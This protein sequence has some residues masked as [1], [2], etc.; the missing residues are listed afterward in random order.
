MYVTRFI[1]IIILF[2][3]ITSIFLVYI[4]FFDSDFKSYNHNHDQDHF[5]NNNIDSNINSNSKLPDKCDSATT[6]GQIC[7]NYPACCTIIGNEYVCKHPLITTCKNEYE[8]CMNDTNILKIYPIN[9]RTEKCIS[10]LGNCCKPFDSINT[11]DTTKFE[12]IKNLN[13]IKMPIQHELG[14]LTDITNMS[15]SNTNINMNTK[16]GILCQT[17]ENCKAYKVGFGGCT[18]Y[19]KYDPQILLSKFGNNE[20]SYSNANS[21]LLY[22]KI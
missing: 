3:F 6:P 17:D 7:T 21:N 18:F 2:I 8:K 5:T 11:I 15:Q 20:S 12:Q 22:K 19:N 4:L 1:N 9:L 16:C 13:K 14:K 10:Q